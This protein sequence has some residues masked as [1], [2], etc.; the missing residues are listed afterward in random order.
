MESFKTFG[1][2]HVI[3]FRRNCNHHVRLSRQLAIKSRLHPIFCVS[4]LHENTLSGENT[5][6]EEKLLN[7]GETKV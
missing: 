4:W 2:T 6:S 3:V 7:M 5:L 1:V